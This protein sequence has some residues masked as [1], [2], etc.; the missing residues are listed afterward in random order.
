MALLVVRDAAAR[1]TSISPAAAF[2][3]ETPLHFR[4]AMIAAVI[5]SLVFLIVASAPG[6]SWL[7]ARGG[8]NGASGVGG[9]RAGRAA[10]PGPNAQIVE[11]AA[12]SG[13]DP[14]RQ[15]ASTPEP[16]ADPPVG[17]ES[18]LHQTATQARGRG[19]DEAPA[20][21]SAASAQRP[22]AG[23]ASGATDGGRGASGFAD[24][25]ATAAGGVNGSRHSKP[26][27]TA[28]RATPAAAPGTAAYRD[29]YRSASA[30]A[31]AAIAQERVPVR[32]R[33]YVKRY[34]VAIHP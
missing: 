33:T 17:R 11:G 1:L 8:S 32:L 10:T 25:T 30:R 15:P 4:A 2:P 12:P 34:F 16:P 19:G 26:L 31:Q 29:D 7:T 3:F 14:Q 23:S 20:A 5:A 21:D 28:S 24:Q 13:S 18:T 27:P 6:S 22:D 9:G